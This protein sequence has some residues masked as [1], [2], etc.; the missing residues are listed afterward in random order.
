MTAR[1]VKR[2]TLVGVIDGFWWSLLG[3][4]VSLGGQVV[5]MSAITMMLLYVGVWH[6]RQMERGFVYVVLTIAAPYLSRHWPV[7]AAGHAA[8]G[9]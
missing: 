2:Q 7:G 9:A 3:G 4:Q 8:C 1:R 6:F 5:A